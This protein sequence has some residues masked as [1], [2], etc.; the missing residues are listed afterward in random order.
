MIRWNTLVTLAHDYST[1]PLHALFILLAAGLG[2][3]PE[4]LAVE[5]LLGLDD[6]QHGAGGSTLQNFW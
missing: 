5:F 3:A 1:K 2:H 6:L 4:H